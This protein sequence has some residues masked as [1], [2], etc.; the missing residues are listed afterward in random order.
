MSIFHVDHTVDRCRSRALSTIEGKIPS[1]AAS[2]TVADA[3]VTIPKDA[4]ASY[5]RLFLENTFL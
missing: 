1:S 4:Q 3:K 5:V 2:M